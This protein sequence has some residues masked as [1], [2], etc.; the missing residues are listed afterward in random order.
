MIEPGSMEH[1]EIGIEMADSKELLTKMSDTSTEREFFSPMPP[2]Y[3]KGKTR[4]VFVMEWQARAGDAVPG[5]LAF[6]ALHQQHGMRTR[7]CHHAD[8]IAHATGLLR[9]SGC[10]PA[11]PYPPQQCTQATH[12]R[13]VWQA[14]SR[15]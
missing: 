9:R 13:F 7:R 14:A 3:K 10:L 8:G 11:E 4:Y 1:F 12:Y 5:P 15:I 6:F 2:N